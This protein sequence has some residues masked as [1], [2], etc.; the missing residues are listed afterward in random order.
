MSA[1]L[2]RST[3]TCLGTMRFP[4]ERKQARSGVRYHYWLLLM[5]TTGD[6]VQTGTLERVSF[7]W[8]SDTIIPSD[9]DPRP[10]SS[11]EL[12]R[13]TNPDHEVP[14]KTCTRGRDVS[15]FLS[16]AF[17]STLRSRNVQITAGHIHYCTSLVHTTM[18]FHVYSAAKI[19]SDWT[20]RAMTT[21]V[22]NNR[23]VMTSSRPNP[24]PL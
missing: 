24:N 15:A 20:V 5:Y 17:V 23:I 11:E 3:S 9:I 6:M 16:R 7:A 10:T 21:V 4:L 2:S 14:H 1:K 18:T 22:N 8:K 13:R 19:L 12:Q